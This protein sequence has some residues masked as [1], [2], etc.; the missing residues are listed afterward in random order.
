MRTALVLLSFLVAGPVAAEPEVRILLREGRSPLEVS[1]DALRVWVDARPLPAARKV[2]LR[3]L[4]PR[5]IEVRGR[6]RRIGAR[7]RIEARGPLSVA[8]GLY[9]GTIEVDAETASVVN[10]LPIETYLLGIVGSEMPASWPRAALEAQ[11]VAA[12]TYALQSRLRMRS[13]GR[14]FDLHDSV[15][16]QVYKGAADIAPSVVA[17]VEATSGQVLAYEHQPAE[18]LFHSTCGGRTRSAEEVFGNEVPYLRERRC[19]W[20]RE[21][22]RHRWSLELPLKRTE[23]LLRAAGLLEGKLRRVEGDEE[24]IELRAGRRRT[25]QPRQLRA[26]LGPSQLYSTDFEAST[27]RGRVR[28]RGRG[29][30]HQVGM[31]QWGARGMAREGRDFREILA[32]YYPGVPIKR[33][34]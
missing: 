33:A 18:S 21:S 5:R 9:L 12:R 7:V 17:A 8:D 27:R 11:A 32:H 14:G 28:L 31:C 6:E 29:F 26:A 10:G 1:G 16:S 22:S 13:S 20:C 2:R 19:P 30:G 34:W 23:D 24:G 15:L 3:F 4:D 25:V